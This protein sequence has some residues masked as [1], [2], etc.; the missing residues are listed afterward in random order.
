MMMEKKF[1]YVGTYSGYLAWARENGVRSRQVH[2]AL[3]G[4]NSLRRVRQHITIVN[5]D[6]EYVP[7]RREMSAVFTAE[8]INRLYPEEE[9]A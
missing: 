1:L 6:P 3:D 5:D 8:G 9:A 2:L 4:P 7:S